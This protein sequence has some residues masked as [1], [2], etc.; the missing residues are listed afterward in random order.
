MKKARFVSE[1][2]YLSERKDTEPKF[3]SVVAVHDGVFHAD[4][5]V[6]VALYLMVSSVKK[7]TVVRTRNPKILDS[8]LCFD[9]G[10]GKFDHHQ[11]QASAVPYYKNGVKYAAC[12]LVAREWIDDAD[13]LEYLLENGLYGVQANDNGQDIK[14]QFKNPFQFVSSYNETW[15][16]GGAGNDEFQ[17]VNFEK[18]V[19]MA[20]DI[21][22]KMKNQYESIQKGK[23]VISS[24]IENSENG[25]VRLPCYIDGF[26]S[27][28]IKANQSNKVKTLLQI[29]IFKDKW[30]NEWVVQVV[31]KTLNSFESFVSNDQEFCKSLP[32]FIFVHPTG[33]M[34]KFDNEESAVKAAENA[35]TPKISSNSFL[36][37]TTL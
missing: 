8:V 12:G 1:K 10:L 20:F 3:G 19:S 24:A 6:S 22:A 11:V 9:V 31:N 2:V 27:E 36:T 14:N 4:D 17:I 29:V 25:I 35:I 18:A 32:G 21:L 15:N 16:N 7:L 30:K 28:I 37:T 23:R 33:F 13:F 5:V 34:A 26:M